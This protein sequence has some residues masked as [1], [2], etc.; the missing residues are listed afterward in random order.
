[1]TKSLKAAGTFTLNTY[2]D[3]IVLSP[4]IWSKGEGDKGRLSKLPRTLVGSDEGE[5]A[6]SI[7]W[8]KSVKKLLENIPRAESGRATMKKAATSGFR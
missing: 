2:C 7:R 6:A 4:R 1:M 3:R 5:V 8:L